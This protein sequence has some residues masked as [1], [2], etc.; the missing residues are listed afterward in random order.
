MSNAIPAGE[1][2]ILANLL[3]AARQAVDA[4]ERG[5]AQACIAQALRTIQAPDIA[6]TATAGDPDAPPS[7]KARIREHLGELVGLI[8]VIQVVKDSIDHDR[9]H[10]RWRVLSDVSDRLDD[11]YTA[12]DE[13]ADAAGGAS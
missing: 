2:A 4:G 3:D 7:I 6:E 8:C 9:D 12:F 1:S 5:E 10:A 13:V 11:L